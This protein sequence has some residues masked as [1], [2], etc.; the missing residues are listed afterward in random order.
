[1][2]K[3]AVVIPTVDYRKEVF[4]VFMERWQSL[5]DKH[6]VEFVK[7]MDGEHPDV[8]HKNETYSA[9][10]VMGEATSCLTNMNGGIRNL[11]FAYVAKYLPDVEYIITLDDDEYPIGDPIQ[12][13]VDALNMRVPISWMS[14]AS[15]YMRGFPYEVRDEAQ[16]VLSH[17]V[18]EGVADWDAV[19][20]LA[21]GNR[22][23]TF[24]KMPIP[25]GVYFPCCAMNIAFRRELLPYI[26]QAPQV[27]EMRIGR[28]DD[29]L[30][31]ITAKRAIDANGWAAVTG[32]ARVH[33][34]RA[35]DVYKNLELEANGY[36]LYE[37][38]WRGEEDHPYFDIYKEKLA[39]WQEFIS[40][41]S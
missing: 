40:T 31:G 14:T 3:I 11:G 34:D 2:N 7:V 22:P 10:W 8:H 18:W 16:V 38:Y 13:H 30:A 29:I 15:E 23:V 37:G 28:M 1:M 12:D 32:Y 24:P 36:K 25:K 21:V 4:D 9:G 26:F 33:H 5:F 41:L 35:S 20:Q 27:L 39:T 6:D 17:G 19:T